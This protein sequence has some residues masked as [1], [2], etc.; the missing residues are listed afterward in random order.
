MDLSS[1]QLSIDTPE[2]VAIEMP[3]AGIGSRFI[4]HQP[5]DRGGL[6]RAETA[7]N[8][9][10]PRHTIREIA[11]LL[12]CGGSRRA[13]A[14]V[15]GKRFMSDRRRQLAAFCVGMNVA[16]ASWCIILQ[17][18]REDRNGNCVFVLPGRFILCACRASNS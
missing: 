15:A 14:N 5:A 3:L 10:D 12:S 2:L 4:A 6:A 16:S 8:D 11:A 1:D 17:V 18:C 9:V 13:P 7:G